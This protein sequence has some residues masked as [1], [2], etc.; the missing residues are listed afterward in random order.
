MKLYAVPL[1]ILTAIAGIVISAQTKNESRATVFTNAKLIDGTGKPPIESAT[2]VIRDGKIVSVSPT[3]SAKVPENAEVIDLKGKTIMPTLIAGHSHLGMVQGKKAASANVTEENVK[4]QLDRYASYGIGTVLS[5]GTDREFVLKLRD[6]QKDAPGSGPRIVSAGLGFGVPNGAP[7][8]AG[9]LDHVHRP[10]TAEE[11]KAQLEELAKLKPDFVKIWIDDF[12]GTLPVKMSRD[13]RRTVISEAHRHGLPVA[14][15]VYYLADAKE[16]VAE[17]IDVLAHSIRD[18][19]VDDELIAAMKEKGTGYI[20]TLALDDA[21]YIYEDQPE[22]AKSEFFKRGIEPGVEDLIQPGTYKPKANAR[23]VYQRAARNLKRLHDGGVK[24][25]MGT[26]SG[27][28]PL[29]VQGF[30]EHRELQLMVA[31]GLTPL[32]A[33][34]AA[35]GTNAELLRISGKT[36]TLEAGKEADL[37]ILNGDP[38]KD[39]RETEKI[40]AVWLGGKKR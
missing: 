1:L 21:F 40:D 2:L 39:M 11:A 18:L 37:L 27:A 8:I 35:T 16:L 30:T 28:T 7:P 34:H 38:S 4:H 36:G 33:I 24:I 23:E 14:A 9:G 6:A 31:A 22:F 13:I 15:H 5:L 20:A 12:N 10:A 32:E 26:D 17:G 29:R 25:G 19:P 3:D